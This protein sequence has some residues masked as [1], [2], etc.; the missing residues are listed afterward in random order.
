MSFLNTYSKNLGAHIVISFFSIIFLTIILSAD[1]ITSLLTHGLLFAVILL[2]TI[3]GVR[4]V[5]NK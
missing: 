4:V 2:I 3:G 5:G 1:F